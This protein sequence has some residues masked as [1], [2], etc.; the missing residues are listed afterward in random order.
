MNPLKLT[1][2]T[3]GCAGVLASAPIAMKHFSRARSAS[4]SSPAQGVSVA[5]PRP[6]PENQAALLSVAKPSQ[7]E[8]VK[9]VVE[10]A[11]ATPEARA[12][13]VR[14]T[15]PAPS[16]A[17]AATPR[18]EI[19]FRAEVARAQQMLLK[20][21]IPGLKA[22]G[23]LG[24]KTMAAVSD[25]QKKSGVAATGQVDEATLAAMEKQVAALPPPPAPAASDSGVRIE[26]ADAPAPAAVADSQV[27][28]FKPRAASADPG[29]VPTL[30]TVA[31]VTRLQ[32][33]LAAAGVYSGATDGKWGKLTI[34]AVTE[35]QKKSG[36]E[37]TGKPNEI[38]WARL[39]SA[40]EAPRAVGA[41]EAAR[42]EVATA[43]APPAPKLA[44]PDSGRTV[45][46]PAGMIAQT[47]PAE[48]AD[49]PRED[50]KLTDASSLE[51]SRP[52][53]A[54]SD[55]PVVVP[56]PKQVASASKT[57]VV[58]KVNADAGSAAKEGI[59]A[60][61]EISGELKAVA[62][63]GPV[64]APRKVTVVPGSKVA[65]ATAIAPASRS[66]DKQKALEQELEQAQAR[67]AMVRSDTRYE[68][69]KYA[70]QNMDLVNDLADKV[71]RDAETKA[72]P[73]AELKQDMVKLEKGLD[74]A[75][76]IAI[77]KKA[78]AKVGAVE[79][80]YKTL[81][82]RFPNELKKEP[83][84]G[85]M[86]KIQ[87]GYEAM[88]SDFSK[89]NFDPI[90]ERCDGFK[91]AIE[92][93]SNDAARVFLADQLERPGVKSKLPKDTLK[94]IQT[95]QKQNK[96]LEAADTLTRAS[97]SKTTS[98]KKGARN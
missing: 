46:A 67:V 52:A 48:K 93:L 14:A 91:V 12:P 88:K 63:S 7:S 55:Q 57:E 30:K 90:V 43:S 50:V 20:L 82:A 1:L 96:H 69:N 29:P 35:F 6:A 47:A 17:P 72:R 26:A 36:I 79:S 66:A 87:A 84:K 97:A 92:M 37:V 54:D 8:P 68:L 41:V 83:L 95:L 34:A 65:A 80:S 59:A 86:E 77:K 76:K 4:G 56:A 73:P 10:T 24:P 60:P 16:V 81:K 21:G 74:E 39:N 27:V 98:R 45:A 2:V 18:P 62:D 44:R 78:E 22:D 31:D 15:L 51:V 71:Q 32:E 23:K 85:T 70:P 38:T 89:G 19:P 40:P 3:L 11:A 9:R 28:V 58:V 5:S 33:R 61:A 13:I 94:E 49:A 75:K 53:A 25:F 64:V 42:M